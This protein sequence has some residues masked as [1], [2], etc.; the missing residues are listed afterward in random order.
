MCLLRLPGPAQHAC[1]RLPAKPPRPPV[2]PVLPQVARGMIGLIQIAAYPVNHFPARAAIRELLHLATGVN[3]G[4]PG[5]VA[6]ETL[7]FFGAT[8]ALALLCSDLGKFCNNC[9]SRV[10]CGPPTVPP[11]VPVP[12]RLPA[13]LPVSQ[14]PSALLPRRHHF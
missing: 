1:L 3:L 14:S 10:P 12:A 6:L 9:G 7:A 8:L 5:F 2:L 11:A 13:C 4:G